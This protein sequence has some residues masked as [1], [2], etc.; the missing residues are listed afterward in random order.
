MD[1]GTFLRTMPCSKSARP[2]PKEESSLFVLGLDL[3]QM[4]DYTALGIVERT[5]V[6]FADSDGDICSE[7]YLHLRHLERFS[8]GTTY[9]VV[10]ERVAKLM[11]TPQ[12]D[13]NCVLVIDATGVGRAVVDMFKKA[14]LRPVAVT[15]TAGNKVTREGAEYGVPK[16]DLIGVLEATM[17]TGRFKVA[18][19]LPDAKTLMD[20]ML[21][22]KRKVTPAGHDTY[23]AWR[24]GQHDDLVLAVALACWYAERYVRPR[25]ISL[26]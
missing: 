17:Q 19:E 13:G 12:L 24:E 16:R 22:F 20:E 4:Q 8:L 2:E 10:V 1:A 11:A 26:C 5:D 6:K 23:E 7:K 3:G 9:P 14:Y 25:I 21:N 15:I 18:K